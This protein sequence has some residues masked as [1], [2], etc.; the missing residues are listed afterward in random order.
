MT[1]KHVSLATRFDLTLFDLNEL[2]KG[3][4]TAAVALRLGVT[5]GAVSC[6]VDGRTHIEMTKRLGL[7][8]PA[9]MNDLSASL[10][11]EGAIGFL[12]D[13]LFAES[14][15]KSQQT[16]RIRGDLRKWRRSS[17]ND[18]AD[19]RLESGVQR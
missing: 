15:P 14:T 4:V 13:I 8:P 17:L 18:S 6:F 7:D 5:P 9:V 16:R 11:R 10:G 1:M 2:L 3:N 12:V 19:A